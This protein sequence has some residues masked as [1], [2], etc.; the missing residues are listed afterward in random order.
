MAKDGPTVGRQAGG[1]AREPGPTG[2]A[3]R[4]WGWDVAVGRERLWAKKGDGRPGGVA[5]GA[6]PLISNFLLGEKGEGTSPLQ[7]LDQG[8]P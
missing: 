8:C 3:R 4:A 7:T 2:A 1:R 5:E 6:R